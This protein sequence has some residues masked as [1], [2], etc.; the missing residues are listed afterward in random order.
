MTDKKFWICV[1]GSNLFNQIDPR[2]EGPTKKISR[3]RT[4]KNVFPVDTKSVDVVKVTESQSLI[5][6]TRPNEDGSTT[7][8]YLEMWGFDERSNDSNSDHYGRKSQSLNAFSVDINEMKHP[9]DQV[10]QWIGRT[11]ILGYLAMDGTIN[12]FDQNPHQDSNFAVDSGFPRSPSNLRVLNKHYQ[13]VTISDN[14]QALA[15]V[16][17]GPREEATGVASKAAS[18]YHYRLELWSSFKELLGFCMFG[19]ADSPCRSIQLNNSP[20]AETE[21]QLCSGASHFLILTHTPSPSC[22]PETNNCDDDG[23]YHSTLYAFGDNRFGQLGL[24]TRSVSVDEPQ[25]IHGLPA[26]LR[27]DCGLFHNLAVGKGGELY[28]FGHNR[29]GQCGVGNSTVDPTVPNLIDLGG[30]GEAGN[31]ID[32]I[33]AQ[34]GSEHTVVLTPSGVWVTGSNSLGQLGL[35]ETQSQFEFQLLDFTSAE[36]S[37]IDRSSWKIVAGRWNTIV[38][39]A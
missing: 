25:V 21:I 26:V 5:L 38:W 30:N 31:I 33:D 27:I 32:V 10:K 11:K 19:D 16:L 13:A 39:A 28:T 15:A 36:G 7:R 12:P 14:G 18:N 20:V 29:N 35:E 9:I 17:V 23:S 8:S 34:C 1:F 2:D 6:F 4:L 37:F 24:G 3:P 22:A